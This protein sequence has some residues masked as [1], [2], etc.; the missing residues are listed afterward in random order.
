MATRCLLSFSHAAIQSLTF[1]LIP[2]AAS[3][4]LSLSVGIPCRRPSQSLGRPRQLIFLCWLQQWLSPWIPAWVRGARLPHGMNPC[5]EFF[6]RLSLESKRVSY[7]GAYSWASQTCQFIVDNCKALKNTKSPSSNHD[8]YKMVTH[9]NES[10]NY[11]YI[12][13]SETIALVTW[14]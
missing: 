11:T 6:S 1:P 14:V 7:S 2:C 8:W 10:C 4:F 12:M 3:F 5:W 13:P 9:R